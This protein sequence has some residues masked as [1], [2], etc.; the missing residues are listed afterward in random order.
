MDSGYQYGTNTYLNWVKIE[1]QI[2]PIST[3]M[4]CYSGFPSE[5]ILK[6]IDSPLIVTVREITKPKWLASR[7]I[8]RNP[9][10]ILNL[11]QTNFIFI[12]YFPLK[13]V[14]YLL[15]DKIN[16]LS[17]ASL[18]KSVPIITLYISRSLQTTFASLPDDETLRHCELWWRLL[19]YED[20]LLRP[21]DASAAIVDR[22]Q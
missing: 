20:C 16:S 9:I 2:S 7:I 13:I 1:H 21:C 8:T 19:C 3:C 22:T 17:G 11:F 15:S 14:R 6:E 4:K 10:Q 18:S 12:E 5:L